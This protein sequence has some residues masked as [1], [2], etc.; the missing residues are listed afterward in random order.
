MKIMGRSVRSIAWQLVSRFASPAKQSYSGAGEDRFVLAWLQVVYGLSDAS[1]IRY[2]DIGANHPRT[3]NNTF[4]LYSRGASGVLIEPDPDQCVLLRKDRPRDTILNV[5]VAFDDRRSAKLKRL[6][7]NVF[8]T[9]L[10]SQADFVAESSKNWQPHQLQA[11]VGEIEIELLPANEILA[12]YFSDGLDF[13]SIDA[14]GVDFPILQSIDFKRFHPKMI[15]VEAS[16][17]PS[18]F[19]AVLNPQGYELIARTPDNVIYRSVE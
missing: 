7:S 18:E 19:D 13:V 6:S 11:I 4:A 14:E 5:G 9:F 8:N 16:R 3:L 12:K 10:Q 17:A 2:C 1:K 15:C